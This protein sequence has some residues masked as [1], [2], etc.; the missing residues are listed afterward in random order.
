MTVLLKS[1]HSKILAK[2]LFLG[3]L[4]FFATIIFFS[5]S[6]YSRPNLFTKTPPIENNQLEKIGSELPIQLKIP[7]IRVDATIVYVGLTPQGN[8]DVPKGPNEVAWFNLG[9][10]P[11]EVGS[12]VISGHYGWKNNIPAVFDNL[13]T[14]K[15]GDRIYITD[16]KG[17]TTS[18]VVRELR[19]YGEDQDA[20]DV[21]ISTDGGAHLNLITCEGVWNK[22]KKSYSRRLVVFTDKEG[23]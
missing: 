22:T 9:P 2:L 20:S 18:F 8:M 10:R 6:D 12:A 1:M 3:V 7:S 15:K 14:L 13:N 5:I 11:G 19:A 16:I 23:A 17:L 21:F 4:I